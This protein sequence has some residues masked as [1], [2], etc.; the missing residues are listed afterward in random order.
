MILA[1]L[2][3]VTVSAQ[4]LM[5]ASA[6]TA[7]RPPV[8]AKPVTKPP[9]IKTVRKAKLS[10]IMGVDTSDAACGTYDPADLNNPVVYRNDA[11]VGRH[12]DIFAGD[13]G[14]VLVGQNLDLVQRVVLNFDSGAD[15]VPT[16]VSRRNGNPACGEK[17]TDKVMTIRF[18][19][20]VTNTTAKRFGGLELYAF[21]ESILKNPPRFLDPEDPCLP[22][23]IS[24]ESGIPPECASDFVPLAEVH[25][26]SIRP[27]PQIQSQNAFDSTGRAPTIE[28]ALQ[29]NGINLDQFAR[30]TLNRG[31]L[32][33]L[34][35]TG[36]LIGATVSR[37]PTGP[38]PAARLS[39]TVRWSGITAPGIWGFG[40][41]PE[42]DMYRQPRTGAAIAHNGAKTPRE[43][44]DT[45]WGTAGDSLRRFLPAGN[46]ATS[47]S[48]QAIGG[49][50][51]PPP[52]PPA[53]PIEAF[54]PGNLLY[55]T[56]G[57]STT[58]KD[59]SQTLSE[60]ASDRWCAA[61]STPAPGPD[62]ERTVVVDKVTLGEIRWG[63]R[64]R[65]TTAFNGTVTAELRD[66]GRIVDTL[67]FSG[68][69]PANGTHV[70]SYPRPVTTADIARDSLGQCFHAGSSSDAVVENS[71]YGINV[72]SPGSD[73]RNLRSI[74]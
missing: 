64:N 50:T 10:Y 20:P 24:L 23:N 42:V 55:E 3:S 41:R 54:D 1:A 12:L 5:S 62:G 7:I 59:F 33:T 69:L 49:A 57:S 22:E 25:G 74:R 18:N 19:T 13:T 71:D 58:N 31:N 4:P 27:L 65:S 29:V 8:L 46:T 15:I 16:I 36:S 56:T 21:D 51:P 68:T 73:S 30:F 2:L 47:F 28:R 37:T 39:G 53:S 32:P 60:L 44:N 67:T 61:L 66:R 48:Y 17:A 52:P 34:T 45:L 9:A 40:F 6:Q 38:N 63:I 14:L 35:G 26:F 43:V 11:G 72:T 70:E